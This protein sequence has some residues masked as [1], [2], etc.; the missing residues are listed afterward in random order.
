M[1]AMARV[2][3]ISSAQ[4]ERDVLA[5]HVDPADEL[6]VVVP[7]VEQSRL[8][9]LANDEANARAQAAGVGETIAHDAP[10]GATEIEVKPDTPTQ[11]VLDAIAEHEPDLI[12]VALRDGDDSSWLEEGELAEIPDAVA[13]VPIA[14]VR[15]S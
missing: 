9:W 2:V 6:I 12:V 4:I 14:R 5:E 10:T 13:G 15:L 1:T 7:A 3:V 8:D 11:I